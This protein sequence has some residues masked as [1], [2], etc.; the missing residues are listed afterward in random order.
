VKEQKGKLD[1]GDVILVQVSTAKD[2]K[3]FCLVETVIH[4]GLMWTLV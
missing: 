3:P 1:D 2:Q 4:E